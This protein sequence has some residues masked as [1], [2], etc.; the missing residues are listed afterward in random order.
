MRTSDIAA[1]WP[2]AR[3]FSQTELRR[4]QPSGLFQAPI[5]TF[6]TVSQNAP[7]QFPCA[8]WAIQVGGCQHANGSLHL[9]Q[10]KHLL[11]HL[12]T[13]QHQSISG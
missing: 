10:F 3:R 13:L 6:A 12:L 4:L 2:N 1:V 11:T 5:Q 8:R 9:R 7:Q